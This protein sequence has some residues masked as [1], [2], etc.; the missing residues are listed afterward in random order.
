VIIDVYVSIW[1]GANAD[2][3]PRGEKGGIY[4]DKE[5][6]KKKR[7]TVPKNALGVTATLDV[8]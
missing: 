5:F 7:P 1:H 8:C 2:Y 3:K 6:R 4:Y